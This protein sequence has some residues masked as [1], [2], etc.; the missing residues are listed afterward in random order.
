MIWVSIFFLLRCFECIAFSRRWIA[1]IAPPATEFR[2]ARIT[3]NTA[4]NLRYP[5]NSGP[6]ILALRRP[7]R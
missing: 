2:L 1:D 5:V 3:L 4:E 7:G 6:I